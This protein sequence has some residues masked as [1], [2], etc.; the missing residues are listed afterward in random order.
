MAIIPAIFVK[1]FFWWLMLQPTLYTLPY[2]HQQHCI[3]FISGS[4][5]AV[6]QSSRPPCLAVGIPTKPW[7]PWRLMMNHLVRALVP[8]SSYRT[9]LEH[10]WQSNFDQSRQVHDVWKPVPSHF[11]RDAQVQTS[12]DSKILGQGARSSWHLLSTTLPPGCWTS[13]AQ[14]PMHTLIICLITCEKMLSMSFRFIFLC[15]CKCLVESAAW[16]GSK[17][18]GTGSTL[19]KASWGAASAGCPGGSGSVL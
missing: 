16:C 13:D 1:L 6:Q 9:L 15:C 3:R 5:L 11:R 4:K 19:S 17:A 10:S 18:W 14:L 2:L 7:K 8:A 12:T